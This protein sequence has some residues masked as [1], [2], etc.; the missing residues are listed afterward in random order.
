MEKEIR[1]VW[2]K[3]HKAN[4]IN[5]NDDLKILEWKKP[6]SLHM[7]IR[8]V[9]DKNNLY[10]TGDLYSAMLCLTQQANLE[11]LG[12]YSLYYFSQKIRTMERS[13]SDF[14]NKKAI[15]EIKDKFKDWYD[16]DL[17]SDSEIDK[18]YFEHAEVLKM[19]LNGAE[20]C[21][22]EEDWCN[23]V[24]L[25]YDEI[26]NVDP[27]CWEWIFDVGMEVSSY[28]RA[29]LIGLQMAYEQVFEEK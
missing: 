6:D 26:D 27:D 11:S 10:I 20:E 15:R 21:R 17:D 8:Y 12:K 9:M 7:N 22:D 1:E 14:N 3:D 19:L 24:K 28:I 5:I 25:N 29:Y 13:E 2:F 18:E 4:Y 23:F 16:I